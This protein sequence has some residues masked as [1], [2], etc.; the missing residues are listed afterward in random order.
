MA[1]AFLIEWPDLALS[2]FLSIIS[3]FLAAKVLNS[4]LDLSSFMGDTALHVS[5]KK[6]HQVAV[7]F[8]IKNGAKVHPLNSYRES[9]LHLA[10]ST[11][12]L[13]LVSYLLE[14]GALPLTKTL[15]NHYPITIA[16]LAGSSEIVELLLQKPGYCFELFRNSVLFVSRHPLQEGSQKLRE[17]IDDYD[18]RIDT[19]NSL[20]V[21]KQLT[22]GLPELVHKTQLQKTLIRDLS[23]DDCKLIANP[24][25]RG[26]LVGII[27]QSLDKGGSFLLSS[28]FNYDIAQELA[29][30][31][32]P[33]DVSALNRTKKLK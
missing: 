15:Y 27:N 30:H 33:E 24:T 2:N 28:R 11:K 12:D 13:K 19:L 16:A 3:V 25:A 29:T 7:R 14:S 20:L 32:S 22:G 1:R 6:N 9:P 10:C 17:L 21:Q 4:D 26:R 23:R 18:R 31:L 5:C 8:L